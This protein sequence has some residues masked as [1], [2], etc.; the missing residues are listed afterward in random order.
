LTLRVEAG[1][2]EIMADPDRLTQVFTNLVGNAINYTPDNG[3]VDVKIYCVEGAV[4]V[5]V[6]DTG[7]GIYAEDLARIFE[8][9]Y[10][11]DHP[12]V[13]ESRGTGLGLSIVKMFV[14]MHGGRVWAQSKVG[15]GST[16]TVLLPLPTAQRD[17]DLELVSPEA[18]I[19]SER[20]HVLVADDAPDIAELIRL[21]LEEEG[22][23]ITAVGR[24]VEVLDVARQQC[25]DLIVLDVL[26]PDM[27]GRAVLEAL[28][29]E[30]STS[31]IPVVMLTVVLDDGTAFELGAAGYLNKPING[32]A[33]REA[34]RNA[35]SR[36]GR[37]LV[38]EDDVDTIEMMRIALRRV[39]YNVD[40]AA[41]GYEA[42]AMARRWR[43][44]AILLDLRLP[45]MDGYEALTHLKRSLNT[46]KIPIIV[47]SAHVADWEIESKR[48]KAMG[49]V[50]FLRK[51]FT[52]NRLVSE[53]DRVLG[54]ARHA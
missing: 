5:D 41:D 23:R 10:R 38:V 52:V 24:G 42:L 45:G 6:Q 37:I 51:P 8:R 1:L 33:L 35:L 15:K 32:E 54:K 26:L 20:R 14:E 16:F 3:T 28:K 36:R 27:D 30:P 19:P 40:V 9:F 17:E 18:A 43:P 31:D 7:I 13:Q 22:Y 34:V 2:P 25:P 46:Q 48:L 11:A 29:A 12:V 50:S 21:Q 39:G 53:I 4:R 44:Q 49:V 47:A